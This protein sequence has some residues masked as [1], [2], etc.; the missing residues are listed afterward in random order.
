MPANVQGDDDQVPL[1]VPTFVHLLPPTGTV[2]CP[3]IKDSSGTNPEFQ[4]ASNHGLKLLVHPKM[5][6]LKQR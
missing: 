2:R 3:A 1:A 4:M 5:L 6:Y